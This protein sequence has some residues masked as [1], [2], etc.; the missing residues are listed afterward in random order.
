MKV[1]IFTPPKF[2]KN[3]LDIEYL[4]SITKKNWIYSSNGRASIYHIL[5]SI[6]VDK[7]LIPVYICHTVLIPLKKLHVTPVFYDIDLEDLNPSLE[8]IKILSQKYDIKVILVASMYGNPANLVEIEKY[9]KESN[10]FMIDD[11]AQS[12]GAK[13]DDRYVGTFGDAGF[14]SF[15]PGKPT[16]GHMGSFFWSEKDINIVRSN[17][18]LVHY[19]RWFDFYINRYKIYTRYSIIYK[20]SVNLVSRVLL[21]FVNI[22]NDTICKF[23]KKILGGVLSD[24][25]NGKFDFRDMFTKQFVNKFKK[26]KNFRILQNIRGVANNH[27]FVI[28]F[29]D[30]NQA[31]FFIKFMRENSI[32]SSNGYK[33]LSDNLD[34]LP[35]AKIIDKCVVELPIENDEE[36]MNYI[37]DKVEEFENNN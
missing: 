10:I 8:S 11:A 35:N 36:K 20:K 21:K 29:F 6:E 9:C 22:N 4:N 15:S 27:K 33:L 16:A 7:V 37:F 34:E 23:E 25:L 14:F 26:S 30:S 19:F 17:H 24:H 31:Q 28:I 32:Y 1:N 18:F 12:F 3:D 2:D 5:K 13:L